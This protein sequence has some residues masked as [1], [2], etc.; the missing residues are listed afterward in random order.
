M[1]ADVILIINQIQQYSS[2]THPQCESLLQITS[3][4][5]E[6]I[7]NC[8]FLQQKAQTIEALPIFHKTHRKHS[9]ISRFCIHNHLQGHLTHKLNCFMGE[10]V[11][12]LMRHSQHPT[13]MTSNL[14]DSKSRMQQQ[15]NTKRFNQ[16]SRLRTTAKFFC[17]INWQFYEHSGFISGCISYS[18]G[19]KRG[20]DSPSAI[21][22]CCCY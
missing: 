3:K 8:Q 14:T 15:H 18:S 11:A 22:A 16:D 7:Q 10:E 5:Q 9:A 1:S 17:K 2:L 19:G 4:L 13:A 6:D 12:I 21:V 20:T